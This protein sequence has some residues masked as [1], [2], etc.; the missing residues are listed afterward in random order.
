MVLFTIEAHYPDE[1]Y[2]PTN[3]VHAVT[4]VIGVE[5][6]RIKKWSLTEVVN[7]LFNGE[8][9][10]FFKNKYTHATYPESITLKCYPEDYKYYFK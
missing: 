8:H 10:S 6:R 1:I 3:T 2:L 7:R 4:G 9:D 5:A